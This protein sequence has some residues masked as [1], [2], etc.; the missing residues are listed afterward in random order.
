[1]PNLLKARSEQ[2]WSEFLWPQSARFLAS[3]ASRHPASST[4]SSRAEVAKRS[5]DSVSC[6][7]LEDG[8]KNDVNA[9]SLLHWNT[10]TDSTHSVLLASLFRCF[11]LTSIHIQATMTWHR[12]VTSII[13]METISSNLHCTPI[14]SPFQRLGRDTRNHGSLAIPW[15]QNNMS[16]W[17]KFSSN[18]SKQKKT[19]L[20]HEWMNPEISNHIKSCGNL[21]ILTRQT[22][23]AEPH[24]WVC[25]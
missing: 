23:S 10:E 11:N 21:K 22:L 7:K 2:V 16:F 6:W 18:F 1:M 25:Q 4:S 8:L 12:Q 15:I 5:V 14:T 9:W 20:K 19:F 24:Q 13:T 17:L 3:A